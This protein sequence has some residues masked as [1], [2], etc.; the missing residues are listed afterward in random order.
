[1]DGLSSLGYGIAGI[2]KGLGDAAKSAAKIASAEQLSSD[3]PA[4]G[5][6][7]AMV[8]LKQAEIQVKASAAVIK[9]SDDMMG[10][11]LDAFA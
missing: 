7:Q 3:N 10:S 11:L 1:M 5:T 4:T 9:R 2:Q 8:E 6:T